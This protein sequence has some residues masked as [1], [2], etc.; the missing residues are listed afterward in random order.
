M[1]SRS[2]ECFQP[3][4][5][6][7]SILSS[8]SGRVQPTDN[9]RVSDTNAKSSYA[10]P[11]FS[12]KFPKYNV[13]GNYLKTIVLQVW[14]LQIPH[15]VSVTIHQVIPIQHLTH[16]ILQHPWS[17]GAPNGVLDFPSHSKRRGFTNGKTLEDPGICTDKLPS[18]VPD[19]VDL[20]DKQVLPFLRKN[21][22]V[23]QLCCLQLMPHK[24]I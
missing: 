10:K 16:N 18:I 6:L 2:A 7:S 3:V 24:V 15:K 14:T 23:I 11:S 1:G 5:T 21:V 19:L 17:E 4:Y 20:L 8:T 9:N 22:S 13:Y 12:P